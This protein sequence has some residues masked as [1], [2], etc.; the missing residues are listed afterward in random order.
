MGSVYTWEDSSKEVLA[1]EIQRLYINKRNAIKYYSFRE[2][3]MYGTIFN[4]PGYMAYAGYNNGC[5]VPKF[6]FDILH[7]PS[8]KKHKKTN[9]KFNYEKKY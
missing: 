8:E 4:Y 1:M 7:N 5:C 3:K 2:T 9:T 6:I